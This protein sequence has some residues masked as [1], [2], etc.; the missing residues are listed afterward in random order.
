MIR[1]VR[2]MKRKIIPYYIISGFS[3]RISVTTRKP[4]FYARFLLFFA[5]AMS[6]P[7]VYRLVFNFCVSEQW[8][9]VFVKLCFKNEMGFLFCR[10]RSLERFCFYRFGDNFLFLGVLIVC[11]VFQWNFLIIYHILRSHKIWILSQIILIYIIVNI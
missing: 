1:I 5:L 10:F 2:P 8:V 4:L 9:G 6:G 11:I 3:L 7:L